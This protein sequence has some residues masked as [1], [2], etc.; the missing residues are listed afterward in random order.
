MLK[1]STRLIK[2]LET[3]KIVIVYLYG[4]KAE[5]INNRNSD[6]DLGIVFT[7]SPIKKQSLDLYSKL[8]HIFSKE[9]PKENIDIALLQFSP[10]N[11]QF[12]VIN[13]GKILLEID[14]EFRANFEERIIKDYLFFAPLQKEYE[15]V[16]METFS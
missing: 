10:V 5:G 12:E 9:F 4:S 6:F 2:K 16:T 15:K 13:K 11:F 7:H 1:F 3:I 14:S 8:H